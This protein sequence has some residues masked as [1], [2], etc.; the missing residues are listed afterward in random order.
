MSLKLRLPLRINAQSGVVKLV[1]MIN[2]R[3]GYSE[4]SPHFLKNQDLWY[5]M[6]AFMGGFDLC[7]EKYRGVLDWYPRG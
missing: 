2:E 4:F 7:M 3:G 6:S 1:L 5:W